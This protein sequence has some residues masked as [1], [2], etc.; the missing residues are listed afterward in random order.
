METLETLSM[1]V[2]V[3]NCGP[4]RGI[5]AGG[6]DGAG[7]G[8]GWGVRVDCPCLRIETRGTQGPRASALLV[9][10]TCRLQLGRKQE[11]HSRDKEC[12]W[13]SFVEGGEHGGVGRGEM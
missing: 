6:P 7:L 12:S 5:G 9:S 2:L 8:R 3:P 1:V 11:T 10:H 4:R 13:K